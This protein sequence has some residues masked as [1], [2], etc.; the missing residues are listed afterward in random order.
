M[1]EAQLLPVCGLTQDRPIINA[2]NSKRAQLWDVAVSHVPGL[3][4]EYRNPPPQGDPGSIADYLMQVDT[5]EE[6]I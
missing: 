4:C 1:T 6:L 3:P 5:I 2:L